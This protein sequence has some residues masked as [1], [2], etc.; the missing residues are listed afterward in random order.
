MSYGSMWNDT[1]PATRS[2]GGDK[3]PDSIPDGTYLAE[4]EDFSAFLSKAGEWYVSWWLRVAEGVQTGK[5][6]QRFTNLNERT[7]GRV[8]A[9]LELVTG[10][11][12]GWDGDLVDEERGLT[13][14]VRLECIGAK[15]EIRQRSRRVEGTVFVDV[16]INKLLEPASGKPAPKPSAEKEMPPEDRWEEERRKKPGKPAVA[17][18]TTVAAKPSATGWGDPDCPVCKGEGCE[19]CPSF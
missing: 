3:V 16:Y 5:H 12:P 15:V 6:V 11:I 14:P 1:P 18:T 10:R 19:D 4:V 2:G 9:D 8:K 17:T 7:A 13:G